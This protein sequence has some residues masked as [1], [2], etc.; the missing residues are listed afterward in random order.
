MERCSL[1]AK[2]LN[3]SN[4]SLPLKY[5]S[6]LKSLLTLL[7]Q[8]HRLTIFHPSSLLSSIGSRAYKASYSAFSTSFFPHTIQK[9]CSTKSPK[10]RSHVGLCAR[11]IQIPPNGSHGSLLGIPGSCSNSKSLTKTAWT[12]AMVLL[13]VRSSGSTYNK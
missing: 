1:N 9:K 6:L 8:S 5:H 2:D 3:R 7:S 11:G 12:A 13:S 10:P 4:I